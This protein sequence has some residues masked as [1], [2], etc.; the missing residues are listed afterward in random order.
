[1]IENTISTICREQWSVSESEK[2]GA[3]IEALRKDSSVFVVPVIDEAGDPIGLIDKNSALI[4]AS[5]PLHYSVM[6]NKSVRGLMQDRYM[7][8][9]ESTSIDLVIN[10]LIA[11][12]FSLSQG[13]FIV[14]R[15]GQYVGV[16]LNTDTLN[17]LVEINNLRA[18]ELAE[19][20]EEMTDSVQK[21]VT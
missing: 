11:E 7:R 14:T 8:F 12:G 19:L 1:M 18:R 17:Y 3:L 10:Q 16:G 5:N 13:G 9:E 15:N 4:V 20:N 6:Q 21:I 2:C